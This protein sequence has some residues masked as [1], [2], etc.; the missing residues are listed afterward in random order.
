MDPQVLVQQGLRWIPKPARDWRF[1]FAVSL[2][3]SEFLSP[4]VQNLS[5]YDT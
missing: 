1:V 5:H 2:M 4:H 3:G